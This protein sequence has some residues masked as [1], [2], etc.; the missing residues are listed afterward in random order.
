MTPRAPE[1]DGNPH[2]R[3]ASW[4]GWWLALLAG[5]A[6]TLLAHALDRWAFDASASY[7]QGLKKPVALYDWYQVL[8]QLGSFLPWVLVAGVLALSTVGRRE[9]LSPSPARAC[10]GLLL[11]SVAL[12]GVVAE[13]SKP[14]IGRMRPEDTAGAYQFMP[15]SQRLGEWSDLG[16]ASSHG[17]VSFAAACAIGW[18]YPRTLLITIP[19]A[20]GTCFTRV[21]NANHF[22][23]DT[24]AGAAIGAL[25]AWACGRWLCARWAPRPRA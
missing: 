14:L 11:A 16:I 1:P 2:A 4:R 13:L 21:V 9:G 10:A 24:V 17:A 23:S 19:L 22:L 20:M 5:I 18:C 6:L 12:A 8:R 3:R 7:V 15:W 25:C